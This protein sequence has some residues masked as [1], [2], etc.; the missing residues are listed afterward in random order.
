M[1]SDDDPILV[2]AFLYR[3]QS[4]ERALAV[5]RLRDGQERL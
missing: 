5:A 4:P 3:I 1:T 2:I